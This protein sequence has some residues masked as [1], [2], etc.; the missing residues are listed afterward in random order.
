M[1]IPDIIILLTTG[2]FRSALTGR[3]RALTRV[4]RTCYRKSR[5]KPVK[6][7]TSQPKLFKNGSTGPDKMIYQI[8]EVCRLVKVP[9][10]TLDAWEQDFPF[11]RAG[12]TNTGHRY[13]RPK[14]VEMIRRIKELLDLK[15][16][17]VA[18]IR[19][20]VEE[21]FGLRTT[22]S[23][24]PDKLK[25]VLCDVRDELQEIVTSID[26]KRVRKS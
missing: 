20:R 3:I 18:G 26:V 2:H 10:K 25:R 13:F 1:S 16:L 8:E 19:R 6:N 22:G 12:R 11:L 15:T 24:H 9:E 5:Q 4:R 21:E 23:V 17:T 14:D 7:E